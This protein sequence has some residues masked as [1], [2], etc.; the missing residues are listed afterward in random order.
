METKVPFFSPEDFGKAAQDYAAYR[1]GF[2]ASFFR[3]LSQEG[4][5]KAGQRILDLGT[6]TGTLARGFAKQG[7]EVTGLDI[8]PEL[9]DQARRLG[10]RDGVR[11]SYVLGRAES[12]PL[13]AEAFDIITA[14][15]CWLWFEGMAAAKECM[16][17]LK[18]GGL[19]LIC[20]FSYLPRRGDVPGRTEELI[21]K[22]NPA[23]PLAGSDGKYEKWSDHMEPAG[24]GHIRSTFYD[25][26]IAF[27]HEEWRGRIRAC[28]GVL[29]L[30]D[31]AKIQAFDRELARQLREEFPSEPLRIAHRIFA[32][33]G[34]KPLGP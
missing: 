21:L 3:R 7:A 13:D 18:P 34:Q 8:S 2:P 5:G 27:T 14:G 24:F 22:Y 33:R 20:H 26:D 23:W 15:Q 29:A 30:R 11:V 32:I 17:M 12:A 31:T 19:L 9:I 4:I 28:N 25:E 10:E 6:G 16:R 1:K